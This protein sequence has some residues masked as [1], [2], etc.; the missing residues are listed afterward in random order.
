MLSVSEL[1]GSWIFPVVH[2]TIGEYP[3]IGDIVFPICLRSEIERTGTTASAVKCVTLLPSIIS[4]LSLEKNFCR[5]SAREMRRNN[6]DSHCFFF[7][8]SFIVFQENRMDDIVSRN[9]WN[10]SNCIVTNLVTL[11]GKSLDHFP[12]PDYLNLNREISPCPA[13]DSHKPR[14]SW[15][16]IE[17]CDF[18]GDTRPRYFLFFASLDFLCETFL[19]KFL[20]QEKIFFFLFCLEQIFLFTRELI[21]L[22]CYF[23]ITPYTLFGFFSHF[24]VGNKI[25]IKSK[26]E[27]SLH[28]TITL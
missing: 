24:L 28:T 6:F 11:Q 2:R 7:L 21:H 4:Y 1:D 12:T 26:R 16:D 20:L 27:S 14:F 15:T 8:N 19:E 10:P 18:L 13:R 9:F 25:I 22:F 17:S 23:W 3:E 5:E